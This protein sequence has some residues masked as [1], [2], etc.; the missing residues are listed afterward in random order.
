MLPLSKT[1]INFGIGCG[2]GAAMAGASGILP[3][4]GIVIAGAI[5]AIVLERYGRDG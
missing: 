1:S 4:V 5:L 2:T 3:M